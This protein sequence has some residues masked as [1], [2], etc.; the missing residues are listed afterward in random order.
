MDS[1][2]V[3]MGGRSVRGKN[4][5]GRQEIMPTQVSE[6]RYENNHIA[7]AQCVTPVK[8]AKAIA[9]DA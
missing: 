6:D 7:V 2:I 8:R 5:A 9:P 4:C 3:R 1:G